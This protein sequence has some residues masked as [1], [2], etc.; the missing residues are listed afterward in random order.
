MNDDLKKPQAPS[1]AW[2]RKVERYLASGH[3]ARALQILD[4]VVNADMPL[5]QDDPAIQ[6]DTQIAWLYKIDL[7]REWGK[8]TEA[9][10]WTCLEC[11]LNPNN[12]AARALKERLKR[13]LKLETKAN[14][15]IKG[16][17]Q[18]YSLSIVESQS[19]ELVAQTY[20]RDYLTLHPEV[21]REYADL[22]QQLAGQYPTNRVAYQQGKGEFIRQ[23]LQMA[24]GD[25]QV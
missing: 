20:F 22:K 19:E 10:A 7:L 6:E 4:R 5:F 16:Q 14:R 3:K 21:A 9:L 13:L 23:V 11:E 2:M 15:F 1:T 8:P 25:I 18:T 12:I 17:P 24:G